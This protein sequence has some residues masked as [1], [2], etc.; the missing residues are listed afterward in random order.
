MDLPEVLEQIYA[1]QR[2]FVS[3]PVDQQRRRLLEHDLRLKFDE[4]LVKA[5]RPYRYQINESNGQ[6]NNARVPW[7]RVFR[8]EQSP[9]TRNGWYVVLLFN[10]EGNGS[11]LSLNLGV[12]GKSIESIESEREKARRILNLNLDNSRH[13]VGDINL[14]DNG[15]LGPRYELGNV[16]AYKYEIG[17]GPTVNQLAE[18]LRTIL[19]MLE[20]LP[21]FEGDE[22]EAENIGP[23]VDELELLCS[24]VM[25]TQDELLPLISSLTDESPQ[26]VLTGPPG[27]GK[28]FLAQKLAKYLLSDST[29]EDVEDRI[30]VVQ[31]HPSYGYE[32]FIEG[33]KPSATAA[34]G[35]DFQVV[36]GTILQLAKDIEQDGQKRVLII[37]E[38]NRANLP[39]VFGELMYLLEYRDKEISLAQTKSFRLPEKLLIIGTLNTADRSVQSVDLALRRRFDFFE[40]APNVEILRKHYSKPGN[41]NQL[42]EKLFNGFQKLNDHL[43]REIGD[44]HLL[45]GHSYF[46]RQQISTEILRGIWKQQLKPLI[47]EYFFDQ[48]HTVE[49]FNF[50]H[51]WG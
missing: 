20:K 10:G 37:D 23:A 45:I 22:V 11:Y 13:L 39:R 49:E 34:G 42:G 38:M 41:R 3:Y 8:K 27:T 48:P 15:N 26:I 50:E 35:I 7:M 32:D 46:M 4:A 25:M 16:A 12:T 2:Q 21:M 51:Y 6:G 28:T 47:E 40:V 1:R 17:N 33:L 18:H 30:R 5:N 24:E 43:A 44:R 9:N 36:P 19:A 14:E 29:N 31:F